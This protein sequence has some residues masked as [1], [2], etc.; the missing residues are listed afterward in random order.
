[1]NWDYTEPEGGPDEVLAALRRAPKNAACLGRLE[2]LVDG[3][4]L[5]PIQLAAA[6]G[7]YAQIA[8]YCQG[9]A[10]DLASQAVAAAANPAE[11][12]SMVQQVALAGG[13]STGEARR[14]AELGQARNQLPGLK[15]AM[16]Q[17]VVSAAKA[18]VVAEELKCLAPERAAEVAGAVWGQI[19]QGSVREAKAAARAAAAQA[20]R[21]AERRRVLEA[22]QRRH[23]MVE[24]GRDGMSWFKAY[25]RTEH[26]RALKAELT[27][28]ARVGVGAM[29]A[30]ASG[31]TDNAGGAGGTR[32]GSLAKDHR[33]QAQREADLLVS[34]VLE[35]GETVGVV[36]PNRG[37][38]TGLAA[39]RTVVTCTADEW[40]ETAGGRPTEPAPDGSQGEDHG[41]SLGLVAE[42]DLLMSRRLHGAVVDPAS[43][44][45]IALSPTSV[46][47]AK[48][49]KAAKVTKAAKGAKGAKATEAACASDG[50]EPGATEGPSPGKVGDW[51]PLPRVEPEWELSEPSSWMSERLATDSR[52]PSSF[53]ALVVRL[54]DQ[55]CRFPGCSVPAF[56]CELDHIEPFWR[57]RPAVEQT[58]ASNLH[59]LCK[60]HHLV[61]HDLDGYGDPLWRVSRDS[62]TGVTTWVAPGG[63]SYTV[64]AAVIPGMVAPEPVVPEQVV[65]EAAG[66]MAVPAAARSVG[67]A[68]GAVA[69][70]AAAEAWAIQ[71]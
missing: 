19:E 4:E 21:E 33:T 58:V 3:G 18:T 48:A 54:R 53:L 62:A 40:I 10:A 31:G 57:W 29:A 47:S 55:T 23:V 15:E 26:A 64:P 25:L 7:I 36:S 35:P 63:E 59:A 46:A 38:A 37:R 27:S 14:V 8:T 60:A 56:E 5:S 43:G 45:L 44:R 52:F 16:C 69:N 61:K 71:T 11:R 39:V 24:E 41:E 2:A 6:Q 1:M 65:P 20:D 34:L 22:P 28:R 32:T 68:D 50:N 9:R 13:M 42:A 66:A 17:G 70:R 12:Y 49:A 51:L 30:P 67:L